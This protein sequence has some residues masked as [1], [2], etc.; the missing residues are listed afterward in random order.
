MQALPALCCKQKYQLTWTV[1][2]LH[3]CH[4][5][6]TSQGR[7]YF[8]PWYGGGGRLTAQVASR[9]TWRSKNIFFKEIQIDC[10]YHQSMTE[11]K[12][13]TLDK[14]LIVIFTSQFHSNIFLN[15]NIL[16]ACFVDSAAH[17]EKS[18]IHPW[19]SYDCTFLQI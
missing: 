7:F 2:W 15:C 4:L 8:K 14:Y 11:I 3:E 10:Q 18:W 9:P 5:I 17:L 16:R 13:N 19:C 12:L 6:N 1:S